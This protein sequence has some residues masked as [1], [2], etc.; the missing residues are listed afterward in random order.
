MGWGWPFRVAATEGVADQCNTTLLRDVARQVADGLREVNGV[1][2]VTK[3]GY[4]RPEVKIL[5][6]PQKLASLGISQEEI[7]GAIQARNM[8]DSGGAINSFLTEKK[9]VAAVK[10]AA[11]KD[12][13]NATIT[14]EKKKEVVLPP[15]RD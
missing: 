12:G 6:E 5:L 10:R 14:N 11:T 13:S 1:A 8:R 9:V 4:R 15:L 2:S 3:T 7:I